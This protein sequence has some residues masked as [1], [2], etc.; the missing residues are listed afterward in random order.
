MPDQLD[1]LSLSAAGKRAELRSLQAY[2]V[3]LNLHQQLYALFRQ[4]Q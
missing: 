2:C 1:S 4:Q 3:P